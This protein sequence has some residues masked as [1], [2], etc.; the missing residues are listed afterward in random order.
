MTTQRDKL[1]EDVQFRI[2]RLLQE[3]PELTQRDLARAVG[4]STGG[5]HY[6]LNALVE[7]GLLKLGNFTSAADKRRYAYKLTPQGI[8]EKATMTRKFLVRKMA[9][10]EALKAEIEDVR[11][12]LSDQELAAIRSDVKSQ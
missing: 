7:K 6:V 2:L 8:V 4:V 9:E 10:Y 5:I 11:G 12:D 3:N 1:R